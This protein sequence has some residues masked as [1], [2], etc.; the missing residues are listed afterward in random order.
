MA[1]FEVTGTV[2][3]FA[4]THPFPMEN[5]VR[6]FWMAALVITASHVKALWA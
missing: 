6:G 2:Q 1:T 4:R 5:M 3:L